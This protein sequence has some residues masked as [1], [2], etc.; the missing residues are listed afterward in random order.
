MTL[1]AET[2]MA[3]SVV[4][5]VFAAVAALGTSVVL[6]V[7]FE[8][9][10]AGFETIAKQ[11]GF[12]SD[13]LNRLEKKVEA[14]D[15]ESAQASKTV[16]SLELKV[17]GITEQTNIFAGSI[18]QLAEKVGC[19]DSLPTVEQV[20][21][22]DDSL[23]DIQR[24]FKSDA[25]NVLVGAGKEKEIEQKNILRARMHALADEVDGLSPLQQ[26]VNDMARWARKEE[27]QPAQIH[28]H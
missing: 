17:D 26:P 5:S 14:V 4:L 18:Q 6:G 10:R 24:Y 22:P 19:M 23:I 21:E 1:N 2:V 9:L 3:A 11:T 28:L 16:R 13:M 25:R 15:G 12:F 8:R 7:G 27:D 20:K